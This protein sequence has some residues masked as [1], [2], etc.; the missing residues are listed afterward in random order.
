MFYFI[1]KSTIEICEGSKLDI[2]LKSYEGDVIWSTGKTGKSISIFKGGV[3]TA[4]QNN[5]C[6]TS[7]DSICIC[8]IPT[9]QVN[10]G[11]YTK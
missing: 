5:L 11:T 6:S 2:N 8:E 3:S 4:K 1:D 7:I 10:L 9:P